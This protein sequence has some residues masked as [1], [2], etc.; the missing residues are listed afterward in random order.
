MPFAVFPVYFSIPSPL[1]IILLTFLTGRKGIL[2]F[3][4][5]AMGL[6]DII[7]SI[8]ATV[9]KRIPQKNAIKGE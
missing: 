3:N 4:F 5:P 9:S 1:S 6:F 7:V 2:D 8:S